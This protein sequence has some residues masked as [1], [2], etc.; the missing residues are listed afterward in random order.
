MKG[1]DGANDD[2]DDDDAGFDNDDDEEEEDDELA[3]AIAAS[4]Q[5]IS[6]DVDDGDDAAPAVKS[7]RRRRKQPRNAISLLGMVR[8]FVALRECAASWLVVATQC[9][10]SLSRWLLRGFARAHR[11]PAIISC[12]F[13]CELTTRTATCWR[14]ARTTGCRCTSARRRV[15]S[16]YDTENRESVFDTISQTQNAPSLRLIDAVRL[17]RR[18]ASLQA[19]IERL[20][21]GISA[22]PVD[23]IEQFLQQMRQAIFGENLVEMVSRNTR[24]FGR[25][26]IVANFGSAHATN[27]RTKSASGDQRCRRIACRT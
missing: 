9:R 19:A 24:L 10:R 20:N 6:N 21:I 22:V 23:T 11:F 3:K 26:F 16:R 14:F 5:T 13:W 18:A 4:K 2:D 12:R 1:K 8:R 15:E 25:V 27:L 7:R 17:E